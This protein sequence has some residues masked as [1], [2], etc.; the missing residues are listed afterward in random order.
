[1]VKNTTIV[2][3]IESLLTNH[4]FF[5]EM[6][7]RQSRWRIQNNDLLQGSVLAPTLFNIYTNDQPHF[8]NIRRFIYADDLCLATQ[9]GSFSAIESG[10]SNALTALSTFYRK[11]HLNANPSKTQVCAFHLK[12]QQA[13]RKLKIAW[14][15]I[16]LG[17]YT[18]PVYL[19]VTLDGHFHSKN[20]QRN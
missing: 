4:R 5:V 11:W 20:A 6:D 9:S 2:H 3:L 7:G 8:H 16:K 10:L 18:Q 1:M 19:G 17:H 12:N 13:N 14:A 15:N